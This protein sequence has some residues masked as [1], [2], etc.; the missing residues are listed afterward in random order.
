MPRIVSIW[1]RG[2]PLARLLRAQASCAPADRVDFGRPLV[3]VAEGKGG[4][5]IVTLNRA[6]RDAGLR[7]G[8]LLSNA[9]SKVDGLNAREANPAADA[10][11]LRSLALACLR[12]APLVSA[13]DQASGADGLFIDSTGAAHLWGGEAALLVEIR[14]R[15]NA[16]GLFPRLAIAD[17]AGASWAL[18][19][20]AARDGIIVPSGQEEAALRPLPIAALRLSEE[21]RTLLN[22]FGY[23]RIGELIDQPRAPFAAR[24]QDV[25]LRIDQALGRVPEPLLPVV[26]PPVYRIQ[27]QFVE[28]IC[29]QEHVVEAATRLLAALAEQLA[30]AAKGARVVRLLLFRVMRKSG[31]PG[32]WDQEE[33]LSIDIAFAAPSRD[34]SHMARLLALRLDR[35]G[36]V[37][38]V[39]FGFEAAAVHVLV[40][41]PLPDRQSRLAM[42]GKPVVDDGPARLVD[43]L[44]QRLGAG[45]VTRLHPQ[46]SHIPERAVRRRPAWADIPDWSALLPDTI[47]PLLLLPHPELVDVVAEV[48]EGPPR[49]FRWRGVLHQVGGSQGPERIAPEWWNQTGT[50]ER[51]YYLVEDLAGRRFWIYR[52]GLYG[53]SQT[54][55]QWFLQGL[56][57]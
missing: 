19:R 23:R 21:A 34:P 52:D 26:T 25:L 18:A 51:D 44:E 14:A 2:W 6:A 54:A 16:Y 46:Q 24:F 39:E 22:R 36:S 43:R 27:A 12:Y 47:R 15:F 56:F 53:Q 1:L 32:S 5:R 45:A 57:A 9:R 41:E 17:T 29:S 37:G 55:P 33:A 8:E 28:P 10:A 11:A 3:L 35:M 38:E 50:R 48:P 13:W 49:Q 40:T 20:H 4:A 30:D 31:P 42:G 7:C